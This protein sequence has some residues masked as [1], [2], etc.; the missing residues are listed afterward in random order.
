ME[1][2]A[3]SSS[4]NG[5]WGDGTNRLL[6]CCTIFL[7]VLWMYIN[8]LSEITPRVCHYWRN[9]FRGQLFHGAKYSGHSTTHSATDN[10]KNDNYCHDYQKVSCKKKYCQREQK[11][12]GTKLWQEPSVTCL[13]KWHSCWAV[14]GRELS[15]CLNHSK[16]DNRSCNHC[17]L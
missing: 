13:W 12:Q 7:L 11:S 16:V 1:I 2:R 3:K 10:M 5:A 6:F 9:S 8:V 17:H 14:S 15:N 4:A